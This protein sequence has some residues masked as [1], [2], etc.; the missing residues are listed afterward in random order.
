MRR[1]TIFLLYVF[2]CCSVAYGADEQN[3]DVLASGA[4]GTWDKGPEVAR[5]SMDRNDLTLSIEHFLP[6]KY[7]V[8]LRAAFKELTL[9][10]RDHADFGVRMRNYRIEAD[11][12]LVAEVDL[13]RSLQNPAWMG[14]DGLRLENVLQPS[15]GQLK[16]EQYA[17]GLPPEIFR[18]AREQ[19]FNI[20]RAGGFTGVVSVQQSS[21]SVMMLYRR[22][23]G[24]QPAGTAVAAVNYIDKLYSFARKELPKEYRPDDIQAFTR[25][26]GGYSEN[27][28]ISNEFELAVQGY[29]RNGTL[30]SHIK[31]L[32]NKAGEVLALVANSGTPEQRL[33][34]LDNRNPLARSIFRWQDVQ[35]RFQTVLYVGL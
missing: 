22:V 19:I 9:K 13:F 25:M 7:V 35:K 29:L 30:P 1:N 31:P 12:K 16:L 4:P 2:L 24:M 20:A 21:F 28:A 8:D 32:A 15:G 10:V 5:W 6:R 18:Y 33:V 26:L 34:F 3:C 17:R 27:A 11:G 14:V 23:V